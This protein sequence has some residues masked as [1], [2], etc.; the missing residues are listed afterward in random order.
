MHRIV[1]TVAL[2]VSFALPVGTAMAQES[3]SEAGRL[4]IAAGFSGAC[5]LSTGQCVQLNEEQCGMFDGQF[6]GAV[7]CDEFECVPF[8]ACCFQDLTCQNGLAEDECLGIG[9][10]YQ[11]DSAECEAAVVC[12]VLGACC[13]G[14][15]DCT[16]RMTY[17]ECADLGGRAM[18][19]ESSCSDVVCLGA[20]CDPQTGACDESLTRDACIASGSNW[21][22]EGSVCPS[23]TCLVETRFVQQT[24]PQSSFVDFNIESFDNRGGLR[25]LLGVEVLLDGRAVAYATYTNNGGTDVNPVIEFDESICINNAPGLD[26]LPL[27][28]IEV[29]DAPFSCCDD[30]ESCLPPLSTCDFGGRFLFSDEMSGS[31][32]SEKIGE[33]VADGPVV[34]E[35]ASTG[36]VTGGGKNFVLRVAPHKAEIDLTVRLNYGVLGAC[37]DPCDGTCFETTES[38]CVTSGGVYQGDFVSCEAAN[39]QV[40]GRCCLDCPDDD[41]G[42]LCLNGATP[43]S[44]AAAGGSFLVCGDCSSDLCPGFEDCNSNG[45]PDGC[46]ISGGASADCDTNGIPDECQ[47]DCDGD[48]VPDDCEPDCDND[49]IP[50]DCEVDCNSDGVPDDCQ[51]L[52]DCDGNAVP[53]ACEPF[54][55]CNGSGV[56]DRCELE[57]NDCDG[58]AIPDDCQPDCDSD[59][60][61]DACEIDCNNDGVPDDCQ[62]LP[63]CNGNGIFD[64]C[65]ILGDS[66]DCDGN[67]V[68]D[69]CQEDCN[70]NG[71]FDQCDLD[72]GTSA[73]CNSNTIPDE[74][75][76]LPDCNLNG[77][78][79]ECD[80]VDGA[81]D[82]D[83]NDIPDECQEDCDSN[84]QADVCEILIDS[85][86][87]CNGDGVLNA[88]DPIG[89]CCLPA[90]A[91]PEC[92]VLAEGCCEAQ[93]GT[94][95]GSGTDCDDPVVCQA[96]CRVGC[97]RKGSL[98]S[99]GHVELRW[100][101]DGN[102]VADSLVQLSNDWNE[103]VVVRFFLVNGDGPLEVDPSTGERAHPGWNWVEM[104]AEIPA[105]GP[106]WW[107]ASDGLSSSGNLPSLA[108]IDGPIPSGEI[109]GRPL[110]PA[111]YGEL[112]ER[113]VR[114]FLYAWAVDTDGFEIR[115]NH[116][117]G[118][119][120]IIRS[121]EAW[122]QPACAFAVPEV[123][124]DHGGRLGTPGILLLDGRE[125]CAP[126]ARLVGQFPAEG[127]AGLPGFDGGSLTLQL[128]D[129]DLVD[130]DGLPP[131]SM[132]TVEVWNENEVKFSGTKRCV[133]RW[134][135]AQLTSWDAPRHWDAAT[136]GTNVGSF[137][138]DAKAHPNCSVT[139]DGETRSSSDEAVLGLIR[140]QFGNGA[141]NSTMRV[142]G[143]ESAAITLPLDDQP[144]EAGWREVERLLQEFG[145]ELN[146]SGG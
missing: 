113:T 30:G 143:M 81:D 53:D 40:L 16:E 96:D 89:A 19:F 127:G 119:G 21:Q 25:P 15:G 94:F 102:L 124:A 60:V 63:D 34:F 116:L 5:C 10:R 122:E 54:E 120:M 44:C 12:E 47:P 32:P 91:G 23:D 51:S 104:R 83:A 1:M 86:L 29:E 126:G 27:C 36:R 72:N 58:N 90:G 121:G 75:E 41:S 134:E 52:P 61:P 20:C 8:G 114:G 130:K 103:P 62:G 49:G 66:S 131:V 138:L 80:L 144:E 45:V 128:L 146:L 132:M 2:W 65:D 98:L 139:K 59:G 22:L 71:I 111:A 17:E 4:P 35:I 13:L 117:S 67:G 140:R 68:P 57:S 137:R 48:G 46:D 79:D 33:W 101:P 38:D 43:E 78:P 24:V 7:L 108:V 82:C 3:G 129:L 74:C 136:I 93:G 69:E 115:W 106:F 105:N 77:I 110:P 42:A 109:P 125:Y 85:S 135:D 26:P 73:D 14:S 28:I 76:G 37:C 9:G 97:E 100:G 84:G 133:T 92:L 95:R 99:L 118:S 56:P 142:M 87:D 141:A 18:G 70:N 55:D 50:D 6:T 112:G 11:G 64:E 145:V 107:R 39:C 123:V 88:C 31:V